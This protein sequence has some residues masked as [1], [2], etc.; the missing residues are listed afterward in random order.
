[1][2]AGPGDSTIVDPFAKFEDKST[3]V[4]ADLRQWAGTVVGVVVCL[5][6]VGGLLSTSVFSGS[7]YLSFM[8]V[9]KLGCSFVCPPFSGCD[10]VHFV[11]YA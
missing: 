2:Q 8:K 4:E 9:L 6:V 3:V 5:N 10:C 1:M 11:V 7:H